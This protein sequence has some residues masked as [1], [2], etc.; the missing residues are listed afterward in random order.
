MSYRFI[1]TP[2]MNDNDRLAAVWRL[3]RA[4]T[5]NEYGADSGVLPAAAG[6]G[7][8]DGSGG[9]MS[10][11]SD[12]WVTGDWNDRTTYDRTTGARNVIDTT[13]SRL[14]AALERIGVNVEWHDQS[15]PCDDCGKLVETQPSSYAWTPQYVIT[16]DG[17]TICRGCVM[18]DAESFID[19]H[20][21]NRDD[22]ALTWLSADELTG[23]GWHDA[24]P[25][26]DDAASGWHPGQDDTPA[27]VLARYRDTA[28]DDAR[29]YV[30]IITDHGQFDVHYRLFIRNDCDHAW[31]FGD[32]GY[33]VDC[34]ADHPD[35]VATA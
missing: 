29:D 34:G 13:P 32:R 5:G 16:D 21:A 15:E 4:A 17:E 8:A 27:S 3:V 20:Y 10:G 11:D 2:M 22:R 9:G 30:F 26:G 35:S 12:V 18:N 28:G 6:I 25:A 31:S 23:Y 1:D 7:Y 14:A 19:S 24:M 33:C